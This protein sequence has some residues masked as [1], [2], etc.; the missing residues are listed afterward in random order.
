MLYS[1]TPMRQQPQINLLRS[2]SLILVLVLGAIVAVLLHARLPA[3]A[4]QLP[5]SQYASTIT[6]PFNQPDYYPLTQTPPPHYRPVD[7]WVGRLI[8]PDAAEYQQV[9]KNQQETDWAWFEVQSAPANA[10]ALM[11]QTVRLAWQN[12][13]QVQAYVKTASRDVRFVPSAEQAFKSGV[14][15][16]I[17]LNGRTQ[18]GPLQSLAGGHPYDDVT[19]VLRGTVVQEGGREQEAGGSAEEK[20]EGRGQR[21]E[22]GEGGEENSFPTP[23]SLLPTPHVASI[24]NSKLKTQNS[25]PTPHSPTLRLNRE[26]LQETGRF[27]GLVKILKPVLT[28][29]PQDLPQKCPG[30][31]PCGSDRFQVQHYNPVSRQFDGA[32]EVIRIPQQPPDKDGVF[33][34]STRD[35]EESPAGVAGWY[36]YGALDHAGVFTVQAMKPRILFQL[37]PQQVVLDY[38]Q[39]LRYIDVGNWQDAVSRR[40]SVQTV[41]VNPNAKTPTTAQANWKLG[42]RFLVLHNYG[43]R[44]GTHAAHESLVAGTYAGHFSFGIGEVVPDPFTNEPI[45]SYDY[46]QVYG[47]GVD[48][49]LSGGQTWA[50]YMGN[51]RRGFMGTRP[52]SDTLIQLDTLT[53]DYNFGGTKLSFFNELVAELSLVG[54]RYRIGD[55]SGDSS[56]T[57]ATSCV[58]DSAQAVFITLRRFREKVEA[59]PQIVRWMGEHPDDPNA[60]RFRRLVKLAQ[61]LSQQL[62]P[63]GVVRW[64]WDQ[65]ADM[66][67]GVHHSNQFISIDNF[68]LKNLATGLIS[69]R[70]AMP[71]QGNDEFAKLFLHNGA[72]LWFLRPNQIGGTDPG[73]APLEP[74]LLLGAWKLPLSNVPLLAYGVIRTLGGVTIPTGLDWLQTIGI[75]LGFSAIALPLGFSTEFF[76]WQ[77]QHPWYRQ[78]GTLLRFLFV[79]ALVQE[80]VFRVLLIPYPLDWLPASAWWS[81]AMLALGLFVGFQWLYARWR[82][83]FWYPAVSTPLL[84]LMTLLGMACTLVYRFTGSLWTITLVHWIA[85]SAW[86]LL[87]GGKQRSPW[88]K[89]PP[90]LGRES[91]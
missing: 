26:P 51:L 34:M 65:N 18:V 76:D 78:L 44:G 29:D 13:P 80:Y 82:W 72:T 89:H 62:T 8:L 58:Q 22:G 53:D 74:T 17:R 68:K 77:P 57:S 16:P 88:K 60:D 75:L 7:A 90:E 38:R 79:P 81:W 21:A 28:K 54:A 19:V 48:G 27:Y 40:G 64:D 10:K 23:Y 30:A 12:N 45:L 55:G 35:L 5:P 91:R 20:A 56:I 85:V 87:L 41:L 83:R 36:V 86:W 2:L 4:A 46:F 39:G 15:N 14:I 1:L 42:T 47:N 9:E 24:Q 66:L 50:N 84:I 31:P 63:M 25:S 67:T 61:D 49:M 73:I 37:N 70:T 71:R 52:V 59:N 6:A 69:W 32:R 11:G 3:A 33:N 43:G